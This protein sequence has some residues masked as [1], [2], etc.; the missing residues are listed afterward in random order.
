MSILIFGGTTEGRDLASWLAGHGH[1]VTLCVATGYGAA[2]APA[3]SLPV[4]RS[5]IS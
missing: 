1:T 4:S 2:L 5:S 3:A